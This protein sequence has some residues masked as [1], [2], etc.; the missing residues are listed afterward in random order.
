MVVI[1]ERTKPAK[2]RLGDNIDGPFRFFVDMKARV[3]T[4]SHKSYLR[5]AG[6]AVG[7]VK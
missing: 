3:S 1:G 6:M 2:R 4:R 7:E 5:F